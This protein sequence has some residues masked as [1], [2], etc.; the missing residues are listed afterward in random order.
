MLHLPVRGNGDGGIYSSVDDLHLFWQALVAGRIVGPELVETMIT[1]AV[2]R[3]GRRDCA[4]VSAAGCI[5]TGAAILIEGY[6]AG[7]SM[8]SIHDPASRTTATV[9]ANSSEGAWGVAG[10]LL[11]LF[12]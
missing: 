3:A 8:R 5:A 12:D 2:R 7:V 6:D 11:S 4:T 10:E 1:P 9:L